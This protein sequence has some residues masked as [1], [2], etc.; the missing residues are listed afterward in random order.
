MFWIRIR[1]DP[2]LILVGWIRIPEAKMTHKN[3]DF[4]SAI[5]FYQNFW[6]SK[7]WVWIRIDLKI[8][9]RIRIK[10]KSLINAR[11]YFLKRNITNTYIPEIFNFQ[12]KLIK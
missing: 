12:Y 6:S 3:I 8:W 10:T 7:P 5:N 4:Y 11:I 2:H 9:I 1:M